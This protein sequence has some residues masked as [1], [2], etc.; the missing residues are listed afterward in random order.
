MDSSLFNF[1]SAIRGRN[2]NY[3]PYGLGLISSHLDL[4][5]IHNKILNLNHIILS[6]VQKSKSEKNFSF[7]K[8]I[9][10]AVNLE[11]ENYKPDFVLITCM[12]SQ[13]HTSLINVIHELRLICD[14][15]IAIGGVHV[16]GS[17]SDEKT[18]TKFLEDIK[19]VNYIF[20]NEAEISL[21][22]FVSYV[23]TEYTKNKLTQ[24]IAINKNK[25]I[26]FHDRSTPT[27]EDLNIIPNH[28]KMF[29]GDLT[30]V[31]KIGGFFSLLSKEKK[32]S[33]ILSNRGC[34]AQCTFCSVRNFNGVGVRRRTIDSVIEELKI[35]KFEHGIDHIMWLDDDFL[36]NRKESLMLFNE[37]IKNNLNITW[38]NTNGVI[39]ASCTEE[40]M[41][42]C[43]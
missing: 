11:I 37:M 26:E 32:I 36:Y 10:N 35:L 9:K 3:P 31:G 24:V 4:L 29:S 5:K 1:D 23:N 40:L 42:C 25:L 16:T 33:T 43:C 34:R 39:A 7:N 18:K 12:F 27:G 8:I 28:K 6:D 17:M 21:K 2:M 14:T 13:T 30:R 41:S 15:P 38:D 22:D 20:L 19:G